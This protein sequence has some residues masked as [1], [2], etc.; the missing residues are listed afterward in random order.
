MGIRV[1]YGPR[2]NIKAA[3]ANGIV[4]VDSIIIT[5]DEQNTAELMFYDD[6][7]TLKHIVSKTKF[8]SVD[9]AMRYAA[10]NSCSGNIVTV[11][12]SGKYQAFIV[13][14]DNTLSPVGSGSIIPETESLL[15]R[16]EVLEKGSHTHDNKE[17]LDSLTPELI[18]TWKNALKPSNDNLSL[19]KGSN[20]A[21]GVS[22]AEDGTM[23]INEVNITKIVQS[24][25]EELIFA[26]GG[27]NI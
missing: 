11:L 6:K 13:Q 9:D 26:C 16:I 3:I 25:D 12:E 19:V 18:E 20:E 1:A 21:N 24:P 27:A 2:N 23:V 8:D 17:F 7:T 4:P 22:I 5:S 10:E 14:P 15:R